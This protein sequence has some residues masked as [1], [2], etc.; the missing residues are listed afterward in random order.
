MTKNSTKWSAIRRPLNAEQRARVDAIKRAM[1]DAIALN[2]LRGKRG[3]TQVQLAETL[4]MRQGSLSELERRD[5]VYLSSLRAYVEGLGGELTIEA[6]FPDGERFPIR[7]E[8]PESAP[9]KEFVH[10][11]VAEPA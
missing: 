10:H 9:A 2:E 4:G 7:L 5:D 3:M 6:S 11:S 8:R 1:G